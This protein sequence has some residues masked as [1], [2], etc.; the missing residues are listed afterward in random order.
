[1]ATSATTADTTITIKGSLRLTGPALRVALLLLI[2]TA[3]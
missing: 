2:T 1:P 3:G